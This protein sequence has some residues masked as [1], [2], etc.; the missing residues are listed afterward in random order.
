MAAAAPF[1]TITSTASGDIVAGARRYGGGPVEIT[2][3]PPEAGAS[4]RPGLVLVVGEP[5]PDEPNKPARS[6]GASP[7]VDLTKFAQEHA[8]ALKGANI[9]GPAAL[10][11]ALNARASFRALIEMGRIAVA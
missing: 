4:P 2:I 3:I 7:V 6:G 10:A 1:R 9:D 8:D 11:N 5:H